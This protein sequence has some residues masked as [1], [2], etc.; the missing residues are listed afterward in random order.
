MKY[1]IF[2]QPVKNEVVEQV[3]V[4][5]VEIHRVESDGL[6]VLVAEVEFADSMVVMKAISLAYPK[7]SVFRRR[8]EEP[9]PELVAEPVGGDIDDFNWVGSRHHY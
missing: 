1:Q 8:K 9:A 6:P 2:R 4:G 3:V 5:G 7:E